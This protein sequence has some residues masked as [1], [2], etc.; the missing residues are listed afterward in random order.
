MLL[1]NQVPTVQTQSAMS[2]KGKN[3]AKNQKKLVKMF[4]QQELDRMLKSDVP[5]DEKK[6]ILA[7][8]VTSSLISMNFIEKIKILFSALFK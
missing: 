5:S 3:I 6:Y 1:L 7:H 8:K 4:E 2:F